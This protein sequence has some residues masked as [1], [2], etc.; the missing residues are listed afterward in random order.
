MT[1]LIILVLIVASVYAFLQHPK[2]G[3]AASGSRLKRIQSST[4][5]RDGSFQNISKTPSLTEGVKMSTVLVQ[6]FFQKSK[7]SKPALKLP[8][9]KSDLKTLDPNKNLLVWFGH[10]SYFLQVDG[11]KMLVDPVFSGS[12]SPIPITTKSFFGTDV[13]SVE[14]MPEIDLLFITHDHW[15]HLDY[16]TVKKLK[17]KVKKIVTGLGVGEHLEFWGYDENI[18]AEMDWNEQVEP[19]PGFQVNTIP[20]RH[21]S[22]RSFRR[23]RSLWVSF[24]LATPTMKIFI[25]GDSGYDTH[26]K[27]AG[28][29]FGPF[30]L[31]ILE[32][33]QYDQNWKYIHMM[34]EEV[35]QAAKDLKAKML[36][37]VHWGKF[38]LSLHDWDAPVIRVRAAAQKEGM[39]VLSPMI[40]QVVYFDDVPGFE[41]WWSIGT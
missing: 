36:L 25:G 13:Y 1:V 10:S 26:F 27:K 19:L 4:N 31:V 8:S 39:E 7:R 9:K 2:F 21:F 32:D 30:D 11:I 5:F 16:E 23:N 41:E 17:P 35:V 18:I 24:A 20:A 28:D 29:A 6:F 14:D 38:S 37:P 3:K 15:D 33:G 12:A 40:G 22:G 34:P